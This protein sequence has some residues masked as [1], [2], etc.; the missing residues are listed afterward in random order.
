MSEVSK[1]IIT[2]LD[3]LTTFL[4]SVES[5]T[6]FSTTTFQSTI[7]A[8]HNRCE[9]VE[10]YQSKDNSDPKL[11]AAL[12]TLGNQILK[13][14]GSSYFNALIE[15]HNLP[16]AKSA[17][18]DI[19]SL[20]TTFDIKYFDTIKVLIAQRNTEYKTELLGLKTTGADAKRSNV[21]IDEIIA[22]IDNFPDKLVNTNKV[23]QFKLLQNISEL[24]N[25]IL[26]TE[27]LIPY[28]QLDI[29]QIKQKINNLK[30]QTMIEEN[31]T[32]NEK[33]LDLYKIVFITL[34]NTTI[35]DHV[36]LEP[37]VSENDLSLS[38][39]SQKLANLPEAIS[40]QNNSYIEE[41]NLKKKALL[42]KGN[43]DQSIPEITSA[44][45][46]LKI[47]PHQL[48]S[49]DTIKTIRQLEP[50]KIIKTNIIDHLYEKTDT[51]SV[52]PSEKTIQAELEEL[53]NKFDD[54]AA[55]LSMPTFNKNYAT[56]AVIK[57]LIEQYKQIEEDIIK[58]IGN[59]ND[60]FK[61]RLRSSSTN[62]LGFV[63]KIKQAFLPRTES[64]PSE[65]QNPVDLPDEIRK[66]K[67]EKNI[68]PEVY[69]DK[70]NHES[71]KQNLLTSIGKIKNLKL[72][73]EQTINQI[74]ENEKQLSIENHMEITILEEKLRAD[75]N[76][77]R[78]EMID[79]ISDFD[80]FPH[81]L[82]NTKDKDSIFIKNKFDV[83][84]TNFSKNLNKNGFELE[85]IDAFTQPLKKHFS[86]KT[87]VMESHIITPVMAIQSNVI[88]PAI[89]AVYSFNPS[90]EK[91]KQS[92]RQ[93]I[94]NKTAQIN[95][96]REQLR[97]FPL[98]G[99]ITFGILKNKED[100]AYQTIQK[101]YDE[102]VVEIKKNLI[103]A[104]KYFELFENNDPDIIKLNELFIEL[105]K[106]QNN[107]ELYSSNY[108][109]M[110]KGI[111][112]YDN[113]LENQ[114]DRFANLTTLSENFEKALK[115]FKEN[116]ILRAISQEYIKTQ[117][118]YK[119][120]KEALKSQLYS[121]ILDAENV[122]NVQKRLD[123]PKVD[124][125]FPAAPSSTTLTDERT[126]SESIVNRSDSL[127]A[128]KL[129]VEVRIEALKIHTDK[130]RDNLSSA[131]VDIFK[132]AIK[133]ESFEEKK[134]TINPK[135]TAK[136]F[137]VT[138]KETS[139]LAT[140]IRT[141]YAG[142][143]NVEAKNFDYFL[144]EVNSF[145]TKAK[146]LQQTFIKETFSNTDAL[147][148]TLGA[149]AIPINSSNLYFKDLTDKI[150]EAKTHVVFL[151]EKY[152]EIDTASLDELDVV[153][154]NI[155]E[156]HNDAHELIL[157]T[158]KVEELYH[159]HNNPAYQDSL[160]IMKTIKKK[161]QYFF[162]KSVA[163]DMTVDKNDK[164][165]LND[166][167]L[168]LK[169][170][171]ES[172]AFLKEKDEHLFAL[173]TIYRQFDNLNNSY[174]KQPLTGQE[175][176]IREQIDQQYSEEFDGAQALYGRYKSAAHQE[177]LKIMNAIK[178]EYV[179][180]FDKYVAVDKSIKNISFLRSIYLDP[181]TSVEDNVLLSSKDARLPKLLAIYRD[182]NKINTT[183]M[184]PN[185]LPKH[186]VQHKA[187]DRNYLLGL[188]GKIDSHIHHDHLE[189]ISADVGIRN[190]FIQFLRSCLKDL[191]KLVT[192]SF[193]GNRF[194][195]APFA[196]KTETLLADLGNESAWLE[197][198]LGG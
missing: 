156:L 152:K 61:D 109:S 176:D 16:V 36:L 130:V 161:Y 133:L 167:Y 177:S 11:S 29:E 186:E 55:S 47:N 94:Q 188:V 96:L 43:R 185:V 191:K 71:Y 165:F 12:G 169:P 151:E 101:N 128:I 64:A 34:V 14:L 182:F 108:T 24:Y 98:A 80:K 1:E 5:I 89:A 58:L 19:D 99:M 27:Q 91:R 113:P 79:F 135:N 171:V 92:E 77:L 53:L 41:I 196:T 60:T 106:F 44:L 35:K 25:I 85:E 111:L 160:I 118:T 23:N 187:R 192:C 193:G 82:A 62:N 66:M 59:V 163:I 95:E 158:N 7:T 83:F 157:N 65:L 146:L 127:R 144:N 28:K 45:E 137:T 52:A 9:Q 124:D 18:E 4:N 102:F 26:K 50:K 145:T 87:S 115:T 120:R 42:K 121:K 100:D 141:K 164:I 140:K 74:R 6:S 93:L 198:S 21:L 48:I 197:N 150:D 32:T 136:I 3:E 123:A 86:L 70:D 107:V 51:N 46:Q 179:R 105:E 39:L 132:L 134:L 20:I 170:T 194:F 138:A 181:K 148:K 162:N 174:T 129:A 112:T 90:E 56:M 17:V 149:F 172:D 126:F 103:N 184:N 22:S 147:V 122:L 190:S 117:N 31:L 195:A 173:L 63:G 114:P 57:P 180:L 78:K 54:E 33:V 178:G 10:V 142:I 131:L 116:N 67:V 168:S 143:N 76:S 15:Q 40:I 153:E 139:D 49:I 30:L 125:E 119:L 37:Y 88:E 183:Y 68:K 154:V 8:L 72:K 75:E 84:L 2:K 175:R 104:K 69:L 38:I 189:D 155:E 159:R 13:S 73:H 166:S 97:E 81:F 110:R